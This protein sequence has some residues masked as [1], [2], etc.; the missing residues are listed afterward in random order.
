[1]GDDMGQSAFATRQVADDGHRRSSL[2]NFAHRFGLTWLSAIWGPSVFAFRTGH[3]RSALA[4]RAMDRS[5][6]PLPWYTYPAIRYLSQF[7]FSDASV[8][9]FGGGQSTFWW[10][11]RAKEVTVFDAYKPWVEKLRAS[12]SPNVEVNHMKRSSDVA[13]MLEGKKFDVIVVDSGTEE[14]PYGGRFDNMV[15]AMSHVVDGGFIVVDNSTDDYCWKGSEVAAAQG[16]NRV[17]FIGFGPGG[18]TEYGT[19][20]YFK[21]FPR[22]L[23]PRDVPTA[24]LTA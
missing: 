21:A 20:V 6:K 5:G 19:S 9:E 23:Q 7:D 8:L 22:L 17:D 1:M 11:A 2:R 14:D 16:W 18:V 4:G 13:A 15:A 10:S 3:F 12:V 24:I